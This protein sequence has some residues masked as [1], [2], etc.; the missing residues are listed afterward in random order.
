M[1]KIDIIVKYFYPVAAGIETN[2]LETYS[3]LAKKG[4]KVDIHTSRD[5]LTEKNKLSKKDSIRG[6]AIFRYPFSR[7]GFFPD[8][9]FG[10]T[11]IVAL[12]N[13]DI[14][15]HIR[16]LFYVL[17]LKLLHKKTFKLVLTPHG[18]YTPEWSIFSPVQRLLKKTYH[19]TLGAWLIN[20]TVDVLRCVSEWERDDVISYGV[21]KQIVTVI[22]NGVEEEA[23]LNVEKFVSKQTKALVRSFGHY[24]I[25]V[26][27]IYPIKNYETT[28]KALP[29]IDKKINFVI[30]GPEDHVMGKDDYKKELVELA[31]KLGVEKRIFFAGVLRGVDKYYAIK[32]SRL[33]V[34]MALWESFCNVVHEGLSQGRVCVVADNTALPYLIKNGKNGFCV[35]TTNFPK[36]ASKISY[37]L[38][39]KNKKR[40]QKIEKANKIYGLEN[41]WKKVAGYVDTLYSELL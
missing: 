38:D 4:W 8:I 21:N 5:T 31:K 33:M 9:N 20:L 2:I 18:G 26:G 32:K 19:K 22:P 17:A 37:I 27:R 14:F 25:Q 10:K 36:V 13:F 23:Y 7:F 24:I 39:P 29:L 35:E 1:K 30:V 16:I 3:V 34:H 40:V 41:S 6:L 28:I 11:D 12:H 15:P